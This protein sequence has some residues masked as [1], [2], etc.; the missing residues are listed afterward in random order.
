MKVN[1]FVGSN[2]IM[3]RSSVANKHLGSTA[4]RRTLPDGWLAVSPSSLS[5]VHDCGRCAHRRNNGL[6]MP[7]VK[8]P[9]LP[10]GVDRNL[11]QISDMHRLT[12]KL[13][14]LWGHLLPGRSLY[15][16]PPKAMTLKLER[17]KLE[18]KGI[19]DE[20]IL[21]KDK[22]LSVLDFKT[23]GS[24]SVELYP[25]Y[26]SQLDIYSFLADELDGYPPIS[27]RGYILSFVP[28]VKDLDLDWQVDL[29]ELKARPAA[30]LEF[31]RKA[32]EVIRGKLP[33]AAADCRIC[34][35]L[36]KIAAAR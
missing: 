30:G 14:A 7:Q 11:H 20:W 27:G 35:W 15:R 28:Q 34:R 23:R 18:L 3:N 29:V 13:P 24:P 4:G 33:P 17:E 12:G 25:S 36:E 9:S 2:P 8:F 16:E 22:K 6:T 26:Q 32:N 5:D 10:G 19:P 31:I 1:W 21:E